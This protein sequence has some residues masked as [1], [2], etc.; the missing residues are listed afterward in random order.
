M[1]FKMS[2]SSAACCA[3]AALVL[4]A[5][6]GWRAV[7]AD[8]VD[9]TIPYTAAG[10]GPA[11]QPQVPITYGVHPMDNLAV[12][13]PNIGVT[14][15]TGTVTW[16]LNG[17]P[18][19]T[20]GCMGDA[21]TDDC[22]I[23]DMHASPIFRITAP[24]GP[25]APT[26]AAGQVLIRNHP[27]NPPIGTG[28]VGRQGTFN[29]MVGNGSS[30][31]T[32]TYQV[33]VVSAAD[34]GGWGDPHMTTVDGVKYDFQGAGDYTALKKDKFEIQTRQRPVPSAGVG[35]A[36]EHTGLA[37]CVSVY[38]GVALLIGSNQ[39]SLEPTTSGQTTSG[40]SSNGLQ[41]WVNHKPATLT[42]SGIDLRAGGTSDSKAALEGR[43]V[44]AAGGAYEF[45]TADG[46]QVVATPDYWI[47]QQTPYLNLRVYQAAATSGLWGLIP[48]GSWLPALPDGTSVGPMPDA[49]AQRYQTLYTTFGNAW[50]VTG[51]ASLFEPGTNTGSLTAAD[52]PRFNAT[53]CTIQGQPTAM[54]VD[55]QVA[56][57][58]CSGVTD[59]AQKADCTFD[60]TVTGNTGFAET[61]VKTQAFKPNGGGWQPALAS[62]GQG[63]G[64][65]TPGQGLPWWLW[66][67]ILLIVLIL[68]ALLARRRKA[69]P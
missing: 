59:P 65:T 21:N 29:V 67:L 13:M 18:F 56:A 10:C 68:I 14:P 23:D 26:T 35:G 58:A 12:L 4:I 19:V 46:M 43:I 1:K 52:W 63:G 27:T 36:N 62:V 11:T 44:K 66:I 34:T 25:V 69:T 2:L 60:V 57:Q 5:G 45:D 39:V 41:L 3:A 6:F 15:Q 20:N 8:G 16:Q 28:D 50:R 33:H 53:S 38:S 42:D 40:K 32:W 17:S 54:P 49:L 55:P 24:T 48:S 37:T 22:G 9:P 64:G 47:S 30:S 61:Y 51:A 31:C 7:L